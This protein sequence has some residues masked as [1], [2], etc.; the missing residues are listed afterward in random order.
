M[1]S[2]QLPLMDGG[3]QKGIFSLFYNQ[4][5]YSIHFEHEWLP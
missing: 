5:D 1:T 2:R 4:K 3:S